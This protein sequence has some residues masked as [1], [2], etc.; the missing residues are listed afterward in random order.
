MG[1]ATVAEETG[2]AP[3][4][5]VVE[6]ID[7]NEQAGIELALERAAGGKRDDVG[8]ADTFQRIDIGAVIDPGRRDA[9]PA[10][11]ASQEDR[12]GGA[13]LSKTQPV[14][15]LPPRGGDALLTQNRSSASRL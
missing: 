6:L 11:M 14:G 2:L 10:P 13:Y 15:G 7:Q 12:F 1:D 8:D 4:G 3:I 9:M 5:A